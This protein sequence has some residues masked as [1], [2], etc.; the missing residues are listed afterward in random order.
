MILV[1]GCAGERIS[2]PPARRIRHELHPMDESK[3]LG[4][5]LG[6]WCA[7]RSSKP[8]CGVKS[9]TG[10]FDSHHLRFANYAAGT[11]DGPDTG[12]V[13]VQPRR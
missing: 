4:R 10:G 5:K 12:R 9:F 2:P 11:M 3:L 1:M 7:P 6:S 8:L 13:Q